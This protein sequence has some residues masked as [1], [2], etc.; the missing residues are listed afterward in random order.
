M[1]E[2]FEWYET[3]KIYKEFEMFSLPT[4]SYVHVEFLAFAIILIKISN[5]L[6]LILFII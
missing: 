2:D 1:V 6:S 5:R 4:G 3:F